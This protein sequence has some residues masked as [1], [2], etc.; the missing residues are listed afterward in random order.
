MAIKQLSINNQLLDID[1]RSECLNITKNGDF[2]RF[3]T[4]KLN[5]HQLGQT[6]STIFPNEAMR[7]MFTSKDNIDMLAL[8][9]AVTSDGVYGQ[10]LLNCYD[11]WWHGL[12]VKYFPE[13]GLVHLYGITPKADSNYTE[14]PTCK[15][16]R[17]LLTRNGITL[18]S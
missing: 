7:V 14:I 9:Y 5:F 3:K 4:D 8:Q 17:D 6:D 12:S 18:T 10:M 2:I 13:N 16:V 1:N 15:W 11:N